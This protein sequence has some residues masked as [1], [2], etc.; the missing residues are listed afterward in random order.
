[1]I[2]LVL[3]F[4]GATLLMDG[5]TTHVLIAYVV[6]AATTSTVIAPVAAS[7]TASA[8]L[9]A[10]STLLKVGLAP[11]GLF[12]FLRS[13]PATGNLRPS[14]AM[15]L[16][17]ILALGFALVSRGVARFPALSGVPMRD[18]IAF[19]VL[20]GVGMLIVHRNLVADMIGLL[21]LGVAIDL[22]GAVMAPQLPESIELSATFDALLATFLGL[23]LVRSLLGHNPGL[24]V[25]DMR[26]LRG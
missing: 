8:V 11:L 20:C 26:K 18:S 12:F 25:E 9:F 7:T 13:N 17:L 19:L 6:L 15:P 16:R 21:V 2:E 24:D 23:T 4:A 10:I 5:R 14:I 3:L 1:M 22:A